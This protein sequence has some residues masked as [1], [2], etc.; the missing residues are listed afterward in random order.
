VA[1]GFVR[2]VN[3]WRAKFK[4]KEIVEKLAKEG[5]QVLSTTYYLSSR[6]RNQLEI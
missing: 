1:R 5:I 3:M 4:L 2:I 6:E